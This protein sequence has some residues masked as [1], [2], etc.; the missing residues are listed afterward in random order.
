TGPA[1]AGQ[2]HDRPG[3]VDL[4]DGVALALADIRVALAVDADGP[5]ADQDRLRGRSAVADPGAV[6]LALRPAGAGERREDARFQ[7]QAAHAPVG[8]VGDQ[9]TALAVEAGVVGLAQHGLGGGAAVAAE[10]FLAVAGNRAQGARLAV[11]LADDGIEPI[12]DVQV[13]LG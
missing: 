12:D 4:A 7:V 11:H 8:D 13:A 5:R 10:A 9:Q 3:R 1:R 6:H 2:G